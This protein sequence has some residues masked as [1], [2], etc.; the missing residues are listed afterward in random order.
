MANDRQR[1]SSNPMAPYFVQ[2]REFE[3]RL[4][5]EAYE[6]S[7]NDLGLTAAML[8]VH[9]HYVKARAKLLGGVFGDEPKHEPPGPAAKAWNATSPNGSRRKKLA[10]AAV[11]NPVG[12][13][14][15]LTGHD[16]A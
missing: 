12:S 7:G 15:T 6:T 5:R 9:K 10:A 2:T 16:E 11:G 13:V 4:I 3:R 1:S 8:G 14:D